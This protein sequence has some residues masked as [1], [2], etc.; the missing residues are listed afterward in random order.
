MPTSRFDLQ[1]FAPFR[2]GRLA[3]R[4]ATAFAVH[5]IGEAEW[6]V[7]A[8]LGRDGPI[9]AQTIVRVT[10]AHKTRV[11][12][13]V[14]ELVERGLVSREDGAADRREY[15]LRLTPAG[16]AVVDELVPAAVEIERRLLAPLTSEERRLF[17][18]LLNKL[19]AI[20]DDE[21]RPDRRP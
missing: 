12:R 15:L 20:V 18:R 11:S 14:A 3:A 7:L 16:R 13:A 17:D 5:G 6:L 10:G 21:G 9:T 1:R 8:S 2:L 4:A 19:E